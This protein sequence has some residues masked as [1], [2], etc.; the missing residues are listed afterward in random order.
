MVELGK[1]M[2]KYYGGL[3]LAVVVL[4]GLLATKHTFYEWEM[5][6]RN[7]E[8]CLR[9]K[10]VSDVLAL[11]DTSVQMWV[12]EGIIPGIPYKEMGEETLEDVAEAYLDEPIGRCMVQV[13]ARSSNGKVVASMTLC[14]ICAST[15][16]KKV[17]RRAIN[18]DQGV[19][20]ECLAEATSVFKIEM[21]VLI[22]MMKW[23]RHLYL[24]ETNY[25]PINI[26]NGRVPWDNLS[27]LGTL[28]NFNARKW[29]VKDLAQLT[30]LCKVKMIDLKSFK[31]WRQSSNSLVPFPIIFV[32]WLRVNKGAMPSL[33]DLSI[34]VCKRDTERSTWFGRSRELPLWRTSTPVTPWRVQLLTCCFGNLN[35]VVVVIQIQLTKFLL[36]ICT[37]CH[38]WKRKR[39][40]EDEREKG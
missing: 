27:N 5:V 8:S 11:I 32:P 38:C 25:V 2:T 21:S 4:G 35:H 22:G 36:Q 31:E 30:K 12:A 33:K 16:L 18:L 40:S 28:A 6:H 9:G 26:H 15:T 39:A 3:S 23:P 37:S 24:P 20:V 17:R 14:E 10:G 29:V 7:V 19:P 1:E 13:G 34:G